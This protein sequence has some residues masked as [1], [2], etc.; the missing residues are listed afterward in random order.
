[1][2]ANI[3]P[4]LKQRFFDA[5]GD[6]LAGGK[7]Y[8]YIAGST[9]PLATYTDE[10]A[11]QANTNPIILDANGECNMWLKAQYYKFVLNNSLDVVQ[12][13]V[14]R[15][16]G[17]S[18]AGAAVASTNVVNTSP[19]YAPE[20]N[21]ATLAEEYGLEVFKLAKDGAQKVRRIVNVPTKYATGGIINMNV[22]FYSPEILLS[23]RFKLTVTLISKKIGT[24]VSVVAPVY[25]EQ[26][27]VKFVV[28]QGPGAAVVANSLRSLQFILSANGFIA[29]NDVYPEDQLIVDLERITTNVGSEGADSN[30]DVRILKHNTEEVF[31]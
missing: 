26:R 30:E 25:T 24:S 28:P 3:S 4:L 23:A 1:M 14:D 29:G 7:L 17:T 5:N 8:S 22:Y 9:T 19:W 2:S 31:S 12:W 13:T 15:V 18:N 11:T 16:L 21:G 6:P 27:F 10:S 20:I